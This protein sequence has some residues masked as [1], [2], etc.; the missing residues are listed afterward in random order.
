MSCAL[1][2]KKNKTPHRLLKSFVTETKA[3]Y[4]HVRPL[5]L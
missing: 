3:F 2:R 5:Y 1:V 4:K